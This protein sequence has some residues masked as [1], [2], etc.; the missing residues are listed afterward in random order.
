[1][2]NEKQNK[3]TIMILV[4]LIFEDNKKTRHFTTKI[5]PELKKEYDIKN[6]GVKMGICEC[7]R[8]K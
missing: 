6:I 5:L 1:M 4:E 8:K 3:P 2:K 7:Q